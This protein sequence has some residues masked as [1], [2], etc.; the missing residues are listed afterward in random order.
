MPRRDRYEYLDDDYTDGDPEP[1]AIALQDA[2]DATADHYD[3]DD[4]EPM[5]GDPYWAGDLEW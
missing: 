4:R 3:P 1:D 5:G 2:R